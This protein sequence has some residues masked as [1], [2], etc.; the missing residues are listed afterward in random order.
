M[1]GQSP[2]EITAEHNRTGRLVALWAALLG[3]PLL[4]LWIQELNFELVPWAC[5]AGWMP[6]IH[7]VCAV[8]V[9]LAAACLLTS[10]RT[11][12]QTGSSWPGDQHG[13]LVR[14]RFLAVVGLMISLFSLLAIIALWLTNFLLGPCQ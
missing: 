14:T 1:A 8:A 11:W 9:L 10:W 7:V 2:A 12:K 4:L 13:V 3:G 6:A 5:S